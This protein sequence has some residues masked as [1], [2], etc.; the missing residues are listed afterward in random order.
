M[1]PKANFSSVVNDHPN[2]FKLKYFPITFLEMLQIE[3][4]FVKKSH[5]HVRS[6]KFIKINLTFIF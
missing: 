3:N 4:F 5:Q 2:L 1:R 6:E